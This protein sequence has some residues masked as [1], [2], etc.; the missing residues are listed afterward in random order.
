MSPI[1]LG[2]LAASGAG[3]AGSYELIQSIFVTSNVSSVSFTSIPQDYKH[4]QIRAVA[5]LS[6]SSEVT[7]ILQSRFNG[8]S[9]ASHASKFSRGEGGGLN[10][11]S[12]FQVTNLS[13]MWNSHLPAANAANNAFGP[14]VMDI[15][16]Y[17]TSTKMKTVRTTGGSWWNS[18]NNAVNFTSSLF[19]NT[20]AITSIEFDHYDVGSSI[21][22]GS[23][24]SLYGLKGA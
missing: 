15:L 10:A 20:S 3:A 16:D 13:Q 22:T 4:L 18:T 12:V 9:T 7:R 8:I 17:S 23:R 1:P 5:R 11:V 2:F 24:F 14:F 21:I 19:P 6:T